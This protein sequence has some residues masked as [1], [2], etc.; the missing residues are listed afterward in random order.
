MGDTFITN[1]SY[2]DYS[3]EETYRLPKE[4]MRLA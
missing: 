4:V 1:M 2:F 3:V